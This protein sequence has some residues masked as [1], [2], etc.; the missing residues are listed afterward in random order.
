MLAKELETQGLGYVS[1][2]STPHAWQLLLRD[3][4]PLAARKYGGAGWR[5]ASP[6]GFLQQYARERG[7]QLGKALTSQG[8]REFSDTYARARESS[9]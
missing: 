4:A 2:G 5:M 3:S 1:T 7:S 9:V 8:L 6:P